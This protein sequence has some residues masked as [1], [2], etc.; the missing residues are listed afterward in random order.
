MLLSRY[1]QLLKECSPK[2]H[3]KRYGSSMAA[4]HN[5]NQHI[6]RVPQGEINANNTF[7]IKKGW[8]DQYVSNFNP[9]G[10]YRYKLMTRRG[11]IET[12]QILYTQRLISF[13]Q[14]SKLS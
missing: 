14:I 8:A 12:A 6:C 10:E 5:G 4:V 2:L 11:R 9:S 7:E 13:P 1:E 3:I